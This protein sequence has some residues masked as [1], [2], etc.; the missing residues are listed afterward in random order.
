MPEP[1][2][3]EI[4]QKAKELCRDDGKSWD[5][6]EFEKSGSQGRSLAAVADDGNRA[7]YLNR[8]KEALRRE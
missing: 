3:D 7:E 6:V 2:E 8:A 1:T 4:L 5:R